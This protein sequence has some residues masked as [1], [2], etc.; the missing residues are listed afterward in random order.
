MIPLCYL[1]GGGTVQ[2]WTVQYVA[3]LASEETN[4]YTVKKKKKTSRGAKG[5]TLRD[6]VVKIEKALAPRYAKTAKLDA[7]DRWKAMAPSACLP[8]WARQGAC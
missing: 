1:R 3:V 2:H 7:N 4:I 6:Y 5:H 8:R